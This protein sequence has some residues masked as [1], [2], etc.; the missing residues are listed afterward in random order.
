MEGYFSGAKGFDLDDFG[1]IFSSF[2][3]LEEAFE[4]LDGP[5]FE[6][7]L[8]LSVLGLAGACLLALDVAA[9]FS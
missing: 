5:S 4:S 7:D 1:S 9:L 3:G 8:S 6:L 2:V